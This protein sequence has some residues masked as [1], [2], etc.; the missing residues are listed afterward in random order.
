M[1]EKRLFSDDDLA[2]YR[3]DGFIVV[4]GL[5]DAAAMRD[6]ARWTDEIEGWPETPGKWMKY[7]DDSLKR[8]GERVLNRVENLCPYHA[9]FGALVTG[10]A[11]AGRVAELL[12]EPAVLFKEKI[13]FKLPG[14][15]GFAAHPDI[16]AG[17]DTYGSLYVTALV[18]VDEATVAN[19]CIELAAGHHLRGM[20]GESWRPLGDDELAGV[21][22][23]PMP[24]APGDT[25][26]FDSF[27]PHRSA[28]NMT[29]SPRRVLYITYNRA[30][31]GDHRAR[32]YADKR[33]SY[34]PDIERDP[35]KEYV[36]RV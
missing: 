30:S 28:P 24:T 3:R 22:F 7:F 29:D 25:V 23:A 27:T 5:F 33:A 9:G 13:N 10:G 15:G 18:S 36:F 35:G 26:F 1:T 4:R 21:A 16:Q 14:G 20:I 12:G 11:L 31:Q 19:G 6:I 32:Y 17:W 34:P 8:P 2:A